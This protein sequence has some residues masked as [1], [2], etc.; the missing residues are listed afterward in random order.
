MVAVVEAEGQGIVG[1]D[2][3]FVSVRVDADA[4]EIFRGWGIDKA[5]RVK[6]LPFSRIERDRGIGDA[7]GKDGADDH[8]D[9]TLFVA[10]EQLDGLF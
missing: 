8:D 5:S 1:C 10:V 7:V 4:T 6:W 3:Q 9:G 2:S